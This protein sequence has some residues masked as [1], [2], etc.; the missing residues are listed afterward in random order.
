MQL[1]GGS[2]S[3]ECRSC[4]GPLGPHDP[5]FTPVLTRS[6]AELDEAKRVRRGALGRGGRAGRAW[7]MGPGRRAGLSHDLELGQ[8]R[9][10]VAG[11]GVETDGPREVTKA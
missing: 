9:G 7:R 4:P 10:I 8:E 2:R 1:C 3:P 11:S 5:S 6:Q